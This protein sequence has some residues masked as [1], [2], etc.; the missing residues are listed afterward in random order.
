MEINFILSFQLSHRFF[1][2][3]IAWELYICKHQSK[4][5]SFVFVNVKSKDVL[6]LLN[7]FDFILQSVN[8]VVNFVCLII[9]ICDNNNSLSLLSSNRNPTLIRNFQRLSFIQ[10]LGNFHFNDS[11]VVQSD[12]IFKLFNACMH[13]FFVFS[14]ECADLFPRISMVQFLINLLKIYQ[15]LIEL[16]LENFLDC[17]QATVCQK[18]KGI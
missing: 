13:S 7:D 17:F 6:L 14:F 5:I 4:L 2:F 3:F 12:K 18:S 11:D 16:L 1:I 8:C 9:C 10:K 15:H